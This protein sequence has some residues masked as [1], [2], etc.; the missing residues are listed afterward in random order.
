MLT[1]AVPT[2]PLA[3]AE[4]VA[5]VC[6]LPAVN[7]PLEEIVPP[8]STDQPTDAGVNVAPNWSVAAAA[9]CCVCPDGTIADPGLTLTAIVVCATVTF[10]L[11]V[12][13]WNPSEIVT[14]NV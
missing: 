9:N 10:T 8:A 5:P 13:L 2:T 4:I 14:T 3:L 7:N 6:T 11:L 1:V 12:M